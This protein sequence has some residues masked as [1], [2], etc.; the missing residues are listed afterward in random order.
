MASNFDRA[1]RL[2]EV[3]LVDCPDDL[4]DTDLWPDEAPTAPMPQGGLLA[5]LQSEVS[6]SVHHL[7]AHGLVPARCF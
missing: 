1:L 4:W 5:P 6:W 3:A 7:H 2:L